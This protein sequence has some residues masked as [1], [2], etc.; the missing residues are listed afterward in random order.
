MYIHIHTSNSLIHSS[1]GG[2]R[3]FPYP[4]YFE[5]CC[6]EHESTDISSR[7]WLC[8]ISG[9]Y[10]VL[11]LVSWGI[12]ILF[13]IVAVPISH[14]QCTMVPFSAHLHQHLFSY[15]FDNSHLNS[16]EVIS[17]CDFDLHFLDDEWC[18]AHFHVP[19]NHLYVFLVKVSIQVL[20]PFLTWVIWGFFVFAIELWG[21]CIFWILTSYSWSLWDKKCLKLNFK[22]LNK[23]FKI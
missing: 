9:L 22:I 11:F 12:S 17:H 20:C 18:W 8:G 14:Q 10:V 23:K 6:N 21:P 15:L 19:D 5:L 1:A 4:G 7:N 3:L 2:H 16:C 13:S